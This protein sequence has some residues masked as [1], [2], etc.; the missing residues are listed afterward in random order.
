MTRAYD[1]MT[2]EEK[3]EYHRINY[4]KNKEKIKEKKRLWRLQN[5]DKVIEMNKKYYQTPAGKKAQRIGN[6]RKSG[7]ICDDW[8]ALY[9]KYINTEQCELCNVEL[10]EDKNNTSTTRC[11]DHDHETG[12]FRNVLCLA[13]N[14][15]RK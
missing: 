12:L 6:W 7:V 10:T 15:R 13:C 8:D 3:R 5:Q 2:V 14:T 4:Q 11:L 9:E 1:L